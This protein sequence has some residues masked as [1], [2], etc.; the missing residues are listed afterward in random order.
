MQY[1]RFTPVLAFALLA[2]TSSPE[3]PTKGSV[4]SRAPE[5]DW[6]QAS[7]NLEREI[8]EHV[9]QVPYL[10]K[11]DDFLREVDWFVRVGE[12]AYETLLD[13]V[14]DSDP[15]VAGFALTVFAARGDARVV[16]HLAAI[17]WP[18][19]DSPDQ[20]QL[21]YERARCHVKLGDWEPMAILVDGLDDENLWNRAQCFKALRDE[22]GHTF[23]YHPRLEAVER[24]EP[25]RRWREWLAER[26]LD[27]LQ[28]G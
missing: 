16:P 17:P 10:Q 23:D 26:D 24:E 12:P 14:R 27:P 3:S 22:T 8:E 2:C 11:P 7:P 21:R 15:K 18:E 20:V 9:A 6:I 1:P 4:R 5:S 25:I 19:G 28:Q 13:V